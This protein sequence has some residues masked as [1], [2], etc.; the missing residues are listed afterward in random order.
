MSIQINFNYCFTELLKEADG[1]NFKIKVVQLV[2][3]DLNLYGK[4]S[5]SKK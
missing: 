3:I 4:I 1:I 2:V 5:S